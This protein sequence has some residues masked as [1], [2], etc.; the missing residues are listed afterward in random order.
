MR[1]LYIIVLIL[2]TQNLYSQEMDSV[3]NHK[4]LSL[5]IQQNNK[6]KSFIIMKLIEELNELSTVLMQTINKPDE[7]TEEVT[8][9]VLQEVGDVE[10]RLQI[11][12][13]AAFDKHDLKYINTWKASKIKKYRSRIGKKQNI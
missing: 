12:K 5:D 10:L 3:D 9:H 13:D 11:V 1:I 6:N 8:E 7:L 4:Q 2:V